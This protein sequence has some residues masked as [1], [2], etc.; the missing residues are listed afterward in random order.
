MTETIIR[1]KLYLAARRA[2]E[3][4]DINALRAI[5]RELEAYGESQELRDARPYL[6]SLGRVK[7]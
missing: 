3:R 2:R 7:G 6:R 5:V 4:M 1:R